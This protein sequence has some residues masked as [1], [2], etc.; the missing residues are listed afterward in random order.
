MLFLAS[1]LTLDRVEALEG[2]RD[3]NGFLATTNDLMALERAT[4]FKIGD[5]VRK[6]PVITGLAE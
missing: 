3:Y 2:V 4:V 1:I 5:N 6:I